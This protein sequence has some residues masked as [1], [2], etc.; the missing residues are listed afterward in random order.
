MLYDDV[1]DKDDDNDDYLK[2]WF[3]LIDRKANDNVC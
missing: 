2:K 3:Q 1:D